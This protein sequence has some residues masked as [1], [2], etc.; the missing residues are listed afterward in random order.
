MEGLLSRGPTPSN[1]K[2][3]WILAHMDPIWLQNHCLL[4]QLLNYKREDCFLL[5]L[6]T[7]SDSLPHSLISFSW[8]SFLLLLH[9]TAV[10]P[11]L[12]GSIQRV[13][14]R[15]Y[16]VQSMHM[17]LYL[18]QGS[19]DHVKVGPTPVLELHNLWRQILMLLDILEF[20]IE[21]K[22]KYLEKTVLVMVSQTCGKMA[23][24]VRKVTLKIIIS[25][26]WTFMG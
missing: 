22:K 4:L 26:I 1:Q 3:F 21:N 20:R 8:H 19:L 2:R 11:G 9:N 25:K 13:W 16:S 24:I 15:Q 12:P 18:H 10:C 23:N 5:Q 7:T 14:S 17:K 6:W